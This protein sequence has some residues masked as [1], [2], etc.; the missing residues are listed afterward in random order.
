MP[1]VQEAD[2]RVDRSRLATLLLIAVT[3]V[4]GSSFFL[5]RDLV[6]RIPATDYLAVRF[7]IAGAVM[8]PLTWR[9]VRALSARQ[10]LLGSCIG[11]LYAMAQLVQ[12]IGLEHTS[13]T[14]SGFITGLYVVLTP[15]LSA[16]LLRTRISVL[17]WGASLMAGAGLAVLCLGSMGWGPGESLTLLSALLFAG[18]I[19]ALGH[20]SR[21]ATAVGLST[22]QIV[23]VAVVCGGAALPGGISTP[24]DTHSWAV[25]IYL[26]LVCGG[27]AMWAQTWAQAQLSP[28]RAAVV[29][30][31]EPV[32]AALFA[33]LVGGESMTWRVLVGGGLVLASMYLSEFGERNEHGWP[34]SPKLLR[35]R[36][37]PAAG[38]PPEALHHEGGA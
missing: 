11:G 30:T 31:M 24:S 29:M 35:R 20:V 22:V 37:A 15:M 17:T 19:L 27:A 3:A 10:L 38:A 32:F 4:W 6:D 14:R 9:Q 1:S 33:I 13:A 18:H 36:G 34:R 5:T 26:A 7:A 28:T 23:A 12:T 8:L 16:C 2:S 25:L 21:A